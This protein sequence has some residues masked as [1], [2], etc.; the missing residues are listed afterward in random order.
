MILH[1]DVQYLSY[2]GWLKSCVK[3]IAA[4]FICVFKRLV[5]HYQLWIMSLCAWWCS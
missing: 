5:L 1:F 3:N 4:G 2:R